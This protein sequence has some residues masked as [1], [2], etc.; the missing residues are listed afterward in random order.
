MT[1]YLATYH[2][3][4]WITDPK[5]KLRD[6]CRHSTTRIQIVKKSDLLLP[7]LGKFVIVAGKEPS[8]V[9]TTREAWQTQLYRIV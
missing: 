4:S 6:T 9:L 5:V 1:F 8:M 3:V 2:G 7:V